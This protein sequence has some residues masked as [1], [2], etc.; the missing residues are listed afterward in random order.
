MQTILTKL[1][2]R[3]CKQHPGLLNDVDTTL[4]GDFIAAKQEKA[5]EAVSNA[6]KSVLGWMFTL[7]PLY[8]ETIAG[9]QNMV[10]FVRTKNKTLAYNE[11][12][13]YASAVG[14]V[15]GSFMDSMASSEKSSTEFANYS[16]Q[17]RPTPRK[18]NSGPHPLIAFLLW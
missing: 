18:L 10:E 2:E 7:D 16:L 1:F 15:P 5:L 8:T 3:H 12:R 17:V 4:V 13:T 6:V 14:Y 9:V 11:S